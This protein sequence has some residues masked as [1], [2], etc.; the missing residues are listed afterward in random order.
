MLLLSLTHPLNWEI[1]K[2]PATFKLLYAMPPLYL[3]VQIEQ[4]YFY[5]NLHRD[6]SSKKKVKI[7]NTLWFTKQQSWQISFCALF[8]VNCS[9]WKYFTTVAIIS[10][11][12]KILQQDQ[13]NFCTD[14]SFSNKSPLISW[15]AL[16]QN[17]YQIYSFWAGT[18]VQENEKWVKATE[19]QQHYWSLS[20]YTC[21]EHYIA[22]NHLQVLCFLSFSC[23]QM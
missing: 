11:S 20:N 5:F 8:Y 16:K 17:P 2:K 13:N 7:Y 1:E 18:W 12:Y 4:I 22:S 9:Q 10:A 6:L 15:Q 14:E 21:K 23:I 19:K 3:K